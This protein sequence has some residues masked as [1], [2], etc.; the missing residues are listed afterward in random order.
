MNQKK[1]R[2]DSGE[3]LQPANGDKTHCPNGHEISGANEY[4]YSNG[5]RECRTC[6]SEGIRKYR[7]KKEAQKAADVY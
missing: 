6:R 3:I 7:A 5:W 1:A 4:L 2:Q